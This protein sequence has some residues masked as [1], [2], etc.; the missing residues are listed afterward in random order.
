MRYSEIILFFSDILA[1]KDFQKLVI[2]S[3]FSHQY[4][5]NFIDI[6]RTD[7]SIECRKKICIVYSYCV[8][9]MQVLAPCFKK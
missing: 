4:G 3:P 7:F 1:Y 9:G 5:A 6:L 2:H 8:I